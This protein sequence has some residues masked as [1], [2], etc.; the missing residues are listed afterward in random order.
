MG[1]IKNLTGGDTITA[2]PKHKAQVEFEPTW[3]L[4]L[5]VND[6]PKFNSLDGAFV[7]RL[8]ILPFV[9]SFPRD[10][11]ERLEFLKKGIKEENIGHKRDKNSM[12][13][14]IYSQKSGIIKFMIETYV[15]LQ[16]ADKGSIKQ[17]EESLSKKKYYVQ[18]N[19]DF[20]KFINDNCVIDPTG[21]VTSEEIT[22]AFK[23]YMGMKKASA[24][25]VISHIK[26]HNRQV[27][28]A[29]KE[30]YVNEFGADV[31]K[32]RRGLT[33]IRLKNQSEI[34]SEEKQTQE[35]KT[36]PYW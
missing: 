8:C 25:W 15:L 29:S 22:E 27:E 34:I 7:G 3:Q 30:V 35:Q 10:E 23:D 9:M 33:G 5:A 17:S 16:T 11:D 32:R 19:D 12:L 31:R 1:I 14:E 18:D 24:K 26:K 2:N 28:T 36:G 21:F 4:I 20:G 6:L 13:T